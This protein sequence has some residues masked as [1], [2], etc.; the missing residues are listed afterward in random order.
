MQGHESSSPAGLM[1]VRMVNEYC[2]CP[3]LFFLE[4]VDGQ[5]CDNFYTEDGRRAHRRLDAAI[6]GVLDD[7]ETAA[8][9]KKGNGGDEEGDP[10][11]E[12]TRSVTLGSERLG[13]VAK[14]DLVATEG[15][16]A[17]PVDTK[18]GR[19]PPNEQRSWEPERVQLM[20]QGLLLRE[21]GY[22]CEK[23][24]L[25]YAGS[26]TRVDVPFSEDLEARTCKLI[27]E[28]RA[29]SRS[30]DLPPPLDDSPKCEGCSL[31]PI[32]LPDETNALVQV[33][34]DPAARHVRR[35][36]P[37]RDPRQAFYVQEQGA[38]I[39]KTG[40]Q[41]VVRKEGQEIGRAKLKDVDQLVLCGNISVSAQTIHLLCE[42][43]VPIVHLSTGHWFYGV[44]AGITL[45]NAYD[46]AAQFAYA[47][48]GGRCLE[49]ARLLVKAKG[50]NQRTL[51]RRN[52]RDDVRKALDRMQR[53]LEEVEAALSLDQLLGCEGKI[54]GEYFGAF[55]SMIRPPSGSL[56]FDFASRNRRPP[57]DP[58]NALL[59]FAYAM[60]VKECTV[61]LL[62]AGLDPYWGV[63]HQPRHGRPAL[64]L[65]LMEEFRPLIA[66]SAVITAINTGAVRA[67]D[68]VTAASGCN[69]KPA[70]RKRLIKMV[71]ARL[72]QLI[73]HPIFRYRCT[74]RQVVRV[75]ARLLAR[76]FRGELPR[77]EGMVTR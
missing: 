20:A 50:Q 76:H 49:L 4:H 64:A 9:K 25:Y 75:Q 28:A 61:A 53:H 10:P 71:A 7:G 57:R 47:A 55:S 22:R 34:E 72:D 31:A 46:R 1:P 74:W 67:G 59:S 69:I 11:P 44:T 19:V 68:F 21:H 48:D 62:A 36:Y 35:L 33:P 45:R 18:R 70:G 37:A 38:R 66:D 5:W 51:L 16:L 54:A 12:T 13:I 65:D 3:R 29:A 23:G 27:E 14:L 17:V 39:G 8:K 26:R 56:S 24:V 30:R 41:L 43:G 60:L 2:Y 42:A 63:Y 32:C 58:V 15:D 40:Q 52:A 77:Y 6:D 73:T